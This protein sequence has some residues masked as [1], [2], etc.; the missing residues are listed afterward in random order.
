MDQWINGSRSNLDPSISYTSINAIALRRIARKEISLSF[1]GRAVSS[2]FLTA[3]WGPG[4]PQAWLLRGQS[5]RLVGGL[6]A[7]PKK[8][9]EISFR[10][11]LRT[12]CYT[13]RPNGRE[14]H[15]LRLSEVFFAIWSVRRPRALVK[16]NWSSCTSRCM[17]VMNCVGWRILILLETLLETMGT[18]SKHTAWRLSCAMKGLL[19]FAQCV[20]SLLVGW[21][22]ILSWHAVD[23]LHIIR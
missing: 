7:R 8:E 1:L 10:A 3:L 13:R 4:A 17:R 23:K 16:Y 21:I 20:S 6:T 9:R 5:P 15:G 22:T 14:C 12:I 19:D 11:I 2:L 18:E